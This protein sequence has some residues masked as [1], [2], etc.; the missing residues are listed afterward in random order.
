MQGLNRVPGSIGRCALAVQPGAHR[1]CH[2]VQITHH[3]IGSV[4]RLDH[5]DAAALSGHRRFDV[6]K[7][8][9]S[10]PVTMFHH[11]GLGCGVA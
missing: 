7:P 3:I 9:A 11:D 5:H 10:E 2:L 6:R 1:Y 4:I 8:E